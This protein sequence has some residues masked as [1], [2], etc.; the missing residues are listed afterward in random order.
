MFCI[1]RE[2][3]NSKNTEKSFVKSEINSSPDEVR[4]KN[5][6]RNAVALSCAVSGEPGIYAPFMAFG[7]G[8]GFDF[9][10][11]C[12]ERDTSYKYHTYVGNYVKKR[13]SSSFLLDS[14]GVRACVRACAWACG[15]QASAARAQQAFPLMTYAIYVKP[16]CNT[17]YTHNRCM[18]HRP[19]LMKHP[20]GLRK[21][22]KP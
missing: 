9:D 2:K 8:F 16:V 7:F 22:P 20:E 14:F 13:R 17:F 19:N 18:I 15:Q 12:R 3:V 11:S 6:F 5:S 1:V 4:H 21:W 10:C